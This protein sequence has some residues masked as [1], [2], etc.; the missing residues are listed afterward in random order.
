MNKI[1]L[2]DLLFLQNFFYKI[3]FDK[4]YKSKDWFERKDLNCFCGCASYLTALYFYKKYNLKSKI[5]FSDFGVGLNHYW[6]KLPNGIEIDFTIDQ[7]KHDFKIPRHKMKKVLVSLD[8]LSL[9]K[10]KNLFRKEIQEAEI[11]EEIDLKNFKKELFGEW[12]LEQV[13]RERLPRILKN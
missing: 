4:K 6:C 11:I 12:P 1:N 9:V 8:N 2:K 5:I 10:E 7:F 3:A 13:C